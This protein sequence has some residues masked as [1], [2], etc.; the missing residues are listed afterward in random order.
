MSVALVPLA[1]VP[2]EV[3]GTSVVAV[4]IVTAAVTILGGCIT[5]TRCACSAF[6]KDN[7]DCVKQVKLPSGLVVSYGGPSAK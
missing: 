2:S 7:K 6:W 1:V 3:E 5:V 4:A